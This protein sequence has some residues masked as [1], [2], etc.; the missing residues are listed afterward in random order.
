MRRE[1][2]ELQ[3]ED[4]LS[5]QQLADQFGAKYRGKPSWR[6][7]VKMIARGDVPLGGNPA[8]LRSKSVKPFTEKRLIAR[9]APCPCGSGK[10]YKRC[11][12]A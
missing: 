1:S 8:D 2:L 12:A 4:W 7:L 5:L 11:C 10:K 3:D 6:R 9:N